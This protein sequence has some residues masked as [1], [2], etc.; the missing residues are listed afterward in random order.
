MI[1]YS[2]SHRSLF[3]LQSKVHPESLIGHLCS[4]KNSNLMQRRN[5]FCVSYHCNNFTFKQMSV[6]LNEYEVVT[7]LRDAKM[8]STSERYSK[9]IGAQRSPIIDVEYKS[10]IAK[11]ILLVLLS[12]SGHQK[13]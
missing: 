7:V 11:L 9:N 1:Q 12:I 8:C 6:Y 4:P 5:Y 2:L 3:I 13:L 10:H